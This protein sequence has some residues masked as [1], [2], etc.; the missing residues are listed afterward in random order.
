MRTAL[1]TLV[2]IQ[3]HTA[4]EA[5]R[6][7]VPLTSCWAQMLAAGVGFNLLEPRLE[8]GSRVFGEGFGSVDGLGC[9]HVDG[10]VGWMDGWMRLLNLD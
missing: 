3:F 7:R 4:S 1:V 9:R 8:L 2:G 10:M 5:T 6:V